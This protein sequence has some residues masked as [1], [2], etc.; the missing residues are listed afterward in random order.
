MV[1]H[2]PSKLILLLATTFISGDLA[3]KISSVTVENIDDTTCIKTPFIYTY[4]FTLYMFF[5]ISVTVVQS[6]ESLPPCKH[7]Q[8]FIPTFS[9]K[10]SLFF[11]S[12]NS[13]S[14]ALIDHVQHRLSNRIIFLIQPR[15]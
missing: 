11:F 12:T 4:H 2:L 6:V 15:K 3:K 7:L 9:R 14:Y 13:Y 10:I 1:P 5:A 8:I